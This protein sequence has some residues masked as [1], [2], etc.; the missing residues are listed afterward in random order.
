MFYCYTQCSIHVAGYHI[1]R[2]RTVLRAGAV[3]Q[4]VDSMGFSSIF[5]GVRWASLHA[6]C[7][8]MFHSA[9]LAQYGEYY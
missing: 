4:A 9:E 1:L 8:R 2:V 6:S 5:R 7:E 3:L